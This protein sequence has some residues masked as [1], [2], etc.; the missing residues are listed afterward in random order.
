[1]TSMFRTFDEL[2][3]T[4]DTSLAAHETLGDTMDEY[5]D[6]STTRIYV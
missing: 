5:A 2:E 3:A 1:M 6:A 4:E